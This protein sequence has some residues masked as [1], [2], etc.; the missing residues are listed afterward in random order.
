MG[1]TARLKY[2]RPKGLLRSL[3][4]RN[5]GNDFYR[6]VAISMVS[7]LGSKLFDFPVSVFR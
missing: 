7:Y 1:E 4:Y 6:H 5:F 2:L 3:M